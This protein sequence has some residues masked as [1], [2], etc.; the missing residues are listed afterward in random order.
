[1]CILTSLLVRIV[2]NCR[3]LFWWLMFWYSQGRPKNKTFS[4]FGAKA[5]ITPTTWESGLPTHYTRSG[6]AGRGPRWGWLGFK[7]F[8]KLVNSFSVRLTPN[9]SLHCVF[10]WQL[11]SLQPQTR[12]GT[13]K[14]PTS[15]FTTLL[16]KGSQGS[17]A[18]CTDW[19]I[20]FENTCLPSSNLPEASSAYLPA[21]PL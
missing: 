17:R 21:G 18:V 19:A 3:Q 8:H 11:R 2:L 16:K 10:R 20:C 1:M 12:A 9:T 14:T 4:S 5:P 13:R 15:Y 6:E 7:V